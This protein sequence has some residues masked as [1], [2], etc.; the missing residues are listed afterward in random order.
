VYIHST[1]ASDIFSAVRDGVLSGHLTFKTI[2]VRV[3]Q[4]GVF[5]PQSLEALAVPI[6]ILTGGAAMGQPSWGTAT[7]KARIRNVAGL[8]GDGLRVFNGGAL[9]SPLAPIHLDIFGCGRD[10]IRLDMNSTASFG[11]AGG[12]AGLVTSGSENAGFGMNVRNASRAL[13]GSDAATAEVQEPDGSRRAAPL[14][15]RRQ[16]C[17]LDD[18][19]DRADMFTWSTVVGARSAGSP[20]PPVPQSNAGHSLVRLNT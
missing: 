20:V 10:G 19:R 6:Q 4:G 9:N 7:N 16:E 11:P 17:A 12:E 3:S 1:D 8:T 13:V 14:K 18:G 15:G 5:I 2:T